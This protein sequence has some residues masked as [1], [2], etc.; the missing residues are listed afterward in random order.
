M[1]HLYVTYK[2]LT[3]NRKKHRLKVKKWKKVFY[4]NRNEKKAR[5]A[6]LISVKN[7]LKKLRKKTKKNII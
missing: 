3:S 7:R 2:R 1:T 4:A 5:V 6:I